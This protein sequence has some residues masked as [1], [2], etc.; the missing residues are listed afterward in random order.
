[1]APVCLPQGQDM[2]ERDEEAG[3]APRGVPLAPGLAHALAGSSTGL[4]Q[5]VGAQRLQACLCSVHGCAKAWGL[6]QGFWLSHA[7]L[8]QSW[9]NNMICF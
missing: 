6:L 3:L 9:I 8:H 5:Q 2:G 7:R 1:M 4:M